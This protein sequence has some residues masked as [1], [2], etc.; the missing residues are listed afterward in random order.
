MTSPHVRRLRL[1]A[2]VRAPRAAAGMTQAQPAG[3]SGLNRA[4][5]ELL[6]QVA[7]PPANSPPS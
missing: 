6:R 2:E 1:T 3:K 5:Y 7:L 4:A